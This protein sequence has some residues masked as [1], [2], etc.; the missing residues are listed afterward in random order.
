MA[1]IMF[2]LVEFLHI[3]IK[4]V[5]DQQFKIRIFQCLSLIFLSFQLLLDPKM[6]KLFSIL[7]TLIQGHLPCKVYQVSH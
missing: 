2:C 7:T 5:K 4:F 1:S 6:L 3:F